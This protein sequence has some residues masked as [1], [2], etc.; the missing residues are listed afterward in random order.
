M[1]IW[2]DLTNSPHINFFKPFI[3]KW[4]EEGHQII[5]TARNLSNTIDLIRQNKWGFEEIGMH[6]G[7][8]IIK[9]LIYFPKRVIL[10]FI[11]LKK[12][13]PEIGISHS[14]FESPIVCKLLKIPS[15][16]LNDNE[17]AKANY[18][19]FKFATLNL[20]PE[21][22]QNKAVKL[23]W[24][25]RYK[26]DFYPGIKEGIYLSQSNFKIE[27]NKQINIY[28]RPE[29]WTAQYYNGNTDFLNPIIKK[30]ILKY[31]VIILT[32]SSD[33]VNHFKNDQFKGVQVPEK[34]LKLSS[35]LKDCTLFI[36]AGGS[37]TRELAFLGIPTLSIYQG[38]L[39]SVD[40]YL[41]KN[42]IIKH[43]LNPKIEDIENLLLS[44]SIKSNA[45]LLKKGR[46]AFE[47]IDSKLKDLSR[48]NIAQ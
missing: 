6:A 34:P 36:G 14:S 2:I 30:L 32:R 27:N 10:L 44:K 28:I 7:K 47:L 35:I 20:L 42:E 5:I 41:I 31:N 17:H 8:N 38:E 19:A 18:I 13:K 45:N 46:D 39:L 26:M 4:E 29:P 33:Q 15:I 23:K 11:F 40:E 1:K 22:L 12:N 37:M 21:F 25:E 43:N 48:K 24:K 16:Y 9:K 3:K